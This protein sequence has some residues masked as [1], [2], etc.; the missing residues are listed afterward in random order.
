MRIFT[1]PTLNIHI[2]KKDGSPAT[3][4]EFEYL[5]FTI[6]SLDKKTRLDK[7][8]ESSEVSEG[9]FVIE[10]TQEETGM[11][12]PDATVEAEINI[13]NGNKRLG[14][15]IKSLSLDNNL[16]DEVV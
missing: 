3:D 13:F 8:V 4:L 1:T 7:R 9:S 16:I 12:E 6:K 15:L 14:T 10:L 11:F 2:R 5:I